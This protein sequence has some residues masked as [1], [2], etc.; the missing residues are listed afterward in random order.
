MMEISRKNILTYLE[1]QAVQNPG[2][3]LLGRPGR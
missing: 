2:K 3:K 1:E